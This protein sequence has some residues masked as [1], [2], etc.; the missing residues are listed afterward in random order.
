MERTSYSIYRKTIE[1]EIKRQIVRYAIWLQDENH[2]TLWRGR[3]PPK[4]KS[5]LLAR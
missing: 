5:T 4:Q 3:T 1:L 2:W